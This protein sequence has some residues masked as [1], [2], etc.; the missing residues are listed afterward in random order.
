MHASHRIDLAVESDDVERVGA[1]GACWD[2]QRRTWFIDAGIELGPFL[3]WLPD[4]GA[5]TAAAGTNGADRAEQ[6]GVSLSVF[7]VRVREIL[8]AGLPEPVWLRAEIRKLQKARSGH[9][10][11][12]LDER[13]D[14]G[15][16]IAKAAGM[17][18]SNRFPALNAKF[19]QGTGG[20]L[21]ADIKVL[22]LARAQ[23]HPVHGF[24][25][26]I[27]DLDPSYTVGDLA[28]QLNRIRETL[29]AEGHFELNR[30]RPAPRE[31]VRVAV[32]CPATSAGQGDFA[33]EADRI[34]RAGLCRFDDYTALFQG[35]AAPQSIR[36]ALRKVYA[37]HQACPYDAL[38]IIRGGGSLTDLSWLNDLQLARWVCRVPIPV[39]TGIGHERDSTIL[40]EV[41]HQRFDTPSK[42]VLHIAQTIRGN[43]R[44]ALADLERIAAQVSRIVDHHATA[45]L[46]QRDRLL[47]QLERT[48]ADAAGE[49]MR[50][51]HAV[52]TGAA[53]QVREAR[54]ALEYAGEA[55]IDAV[56]N[57]LC[58]VE[59]ALEQ[60]HDG[61]T[62]RLELQH[63]ALA[64][65]ID[66]LAQ[67]VLHRAHTDLGTVREDLE[68]RFQSIVHGAESQAGTMAAAA[69]TQLQAVA[70]QAQA[71]L[72][73]AGRD[74]D[75]HQQTLAR[76]GA[77]QLALAGGTLESTLER[78]EAGVASIRRDAAGQI[79]AYAR[80][81]IG[82]GPESTL[83]RGY[84]I[85]RTPEG[86]AVSSRQDALRHREM[87]I[88]FR[89]GR[90]AVANREYQ[91]E[92]RR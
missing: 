86:E 30:Q 60:A 33:S 7:L 5:I 46:N 37:A 65:A 18:W 73:A 17:I 68:R 19:V 63:A 23:F 57:R 24:D 44:E 66:R 71:T 13:T 28:A 15:V 21:K 47:D 91:G 9:V 84:A 61:L 50:A 35:A 34:D 40:D 54:R 67:T 41:A 62:H 36:D 38:A 69:Q 20:E 48:V 70:L 43:A 1:L 56:G 59:M 14:Q 89:D 64:G 12:E 76:S 78:I 22:V 87:T 32:V 90:L 55:L 85:A 42:V 4:P 92:D 3:R 16:A 2:P 31:F 27:E 25:L 53:Q 74:L 8:H 11:L 51:D 29:K 52:C 58:D 10:Y 72:E 6:Q 49:V 82:M 81:I 45:L 26:V 79:E 77:H 39:L 80:T 75:H 88:Q 83:E